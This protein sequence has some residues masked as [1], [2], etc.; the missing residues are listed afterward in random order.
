MLI[1]DEVQFAF[2]FL[3]SFISAKTVV[4]REALCQK[5]KTRRTGLLTTAETS[6]H[7]M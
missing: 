5:K 7:T 6:S 4:R 3:V 1:P 2:I